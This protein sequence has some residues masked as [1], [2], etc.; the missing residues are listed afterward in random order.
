MAEARKLDTP[1]RSTETS[2]PDLRSHYP[3]FRELLLRR[4][5]EILPRQ[6]AAR[7]NLN[8]QVMESPGDEADVSVL[9]TSADYFL[10]LANNQQAELIAIRDALDRMDRGVYG[11][12]ESCEEPISIERLR[13]LPYARYCIEDQSALEK[14]RMTVVPK[15]YPKL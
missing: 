5:S 4:Q 12:C 3:E 11:I 13:K 9:D 7:A 8:E 14:G 2:T 15:P 10:K 6:Q 1:V